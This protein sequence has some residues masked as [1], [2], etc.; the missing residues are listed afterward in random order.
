MLKDEEMLQLRASYIE[1][2]KLVQEYGYGE[3]SGILKILM[4]QVNCID[5]NKNGREK[6][7]FL[8]DSYTKRIQGKGGLVDF[9]RYNKNSEVYNTLNEKLGGELEKVWGILKDYL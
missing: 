3:Y 6:L 5:S 4:E 2:G 9:V 8:I 7:Q 1:I